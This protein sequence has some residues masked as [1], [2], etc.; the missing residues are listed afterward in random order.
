MAKISKDSERISIKFKNRLTFLLDKEDLD[1]I[2]F[3]QKSKISS[4]PIRNAINFGIIPSVLILIKI[5]NFFSISFDYLMAEDDENDF[6]ES[7]TNPSFFERYEF[8]RNERKLNHSQIANVMPF[9]R[10]VICEWKRNGTIP[11]IDNLKALS[12]FFNVSIDYLLGRTDYR[13]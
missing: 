3:C 12:N 4:Q 8:L 10:N 13:K 2:S 7:A 1:V 11:S 5:A 6:I 9:G